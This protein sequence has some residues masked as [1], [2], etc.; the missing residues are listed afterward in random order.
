M[1]APG[2]VPS[3][4]EGKVELNPACSAVQRRWGLLKTDPA[5]R[6]RRRTKFELALNQMR[7]GVGGREGERGQIEGGPHYPSLEAV[8]VK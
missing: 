7:D 6:L 2:V 3:Q 4:T 5:R 1:C 8:Q